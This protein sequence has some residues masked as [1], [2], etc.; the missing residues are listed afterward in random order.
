MSSGLY[1]TAFSCKNSCPLDYGLLF[2][3]VKTCPPWLRTTAYPRANSCPIDS[4]TTASLSENIC[5]LDYR[6]VFLQVKIIFPLTTENKKYCPLDYRLL[7]PKWKLLSKN[8]CF[9]KW[10]LLTMDYCF[11]ALLTKDF[12]FPKW[13]LLSLDCGV[14]FPQVKNSWLLEYGLLLPQVQNT[15]YKSENNSCPLY[16]RQLLPKVQ[17]LVPCVRRFAFPS[18]NFGLRTT[19]PL[20]ENSC[21]LTTD[22]CFPNWKL[23]SPW[24][25]T[26]K[27]LIPWTTDYC[28]RCEKSC[29]LDYGL[30]LPKLKMSTD[31]TKFPKWKRLPLDYRLLISQWTLLTTDYWVPKWQLLYPGLR[32]TDTSNWQWYWLHALD[33]GLLEVDNPTHM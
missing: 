22:W 31:S 5:P 7:L 6:L 13:K 18:E 17:N 23:L 27:T 30:L 12:C 16:Y 2:H 15:A 24:V 3:Q 11:P 10:K 14:L 8:F 4:L 32:T 26:V 1:I 25:Q 19:S 9:P 29:S 33:Y 21:P 28:F 20:C